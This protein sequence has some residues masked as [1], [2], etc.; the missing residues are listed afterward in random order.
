[1]SKSG[2]ISFCD[3]KCTIN[4]A[5]LPRINSTT[6]VITATTNKICINP[7][8]IEPKNPIAQRISSTTK[9]VQSIIFYLSF[10]KIVPTNKIHPPDK[11]SETV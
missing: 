3:V 6:R 1:M 7:P 5:L 8:P 4:Q 9:I 10:L 11:L 2:N